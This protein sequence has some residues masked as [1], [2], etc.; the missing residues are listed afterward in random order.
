MVFLTSCFS[1][2]EPEILKFLIFHSN[3]RFVEFEEILSPFV[4]N[5]LIHT[6]LQPLI[7]FIYTFMPSRSAEFQS[8]LYAWKLS[9]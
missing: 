4:F 3:Y 2:G 9:R 7:H 1:K 6:F 5:L 8:L